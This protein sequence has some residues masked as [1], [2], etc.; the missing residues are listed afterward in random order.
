MR[1]DVK[2]TLPPWGPEQ[3]LKWFLN[4]RIQRSYHDDVLA[5][6]E[7]LRKSGLPGLVVQ[8]YGNLTFNPDKFP[9]FAIRVGDFSQSKKTIL[10][11][12]GVHGYET[13]GVKGA[14]LFLEEHALNYSAHFNFV[15]APCI[16]PW[17]YETINRL[18]PIMEN[19]NREF[20][21]EWKAEESRLLM[22]YLSGLGVE[23]DAHID[24]HETT[25]SDRLFLPEEYAKNGIELHA[26]DIDIPD[27]F[28][29]IGVKGF[30][31]REL[32]RAMMDSVGKV[33]HIA[34]PDQRGMILDIPLSHEGV[35]HANIPGLC[36]ELTAAKSRLGAFTTEMYPD[37]QRLK[38]LGVGKG[39][40]ICNESQVACIRGALDFWV[41]AE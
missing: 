38:A 35:I 8:S 7:A 28:Y 23:F 21:S 30:P 32:E 19:P 27:G 15:V 31:R 33:T 25:D 18:D 10:I 22:S 24:L 12:G 6:V 4:Q 29:L 11:T 16:S 36:A 20:K 2:K 14:L 37:S 13:S 1:S 41:G 3:K 40:V 9:L 34:R 26:K 17:S 5:R 39:D